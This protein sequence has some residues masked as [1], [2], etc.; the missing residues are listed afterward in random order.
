MR[1]RARAIVIPI[2]R[3]TG[4]MCYQL[5]CVPTIQHCSDPIQPIPS[6]LIPCLT[7]GKHSICFCW[8]SELMHLLPTL[9]NIYPS[10]PFWTVHPHLQGCRLLLLVILVT[11]YFFH[12]IPDP[13]DSMPSV[14]PNGYHPW[15]SWNGIILLL[16]FSPSYQTWIFTLDLYNA[17]FLLE[18]AD[19]C[20]PIYFW[21]S[22]M[23]FLFNFWKFFIPYFLLLLLSFFHNT[24][25]TLSGSLCGCFY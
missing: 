18:L 9:F 6:F 5:L 14:F 4:F 23:I 10:P 25:W 24:K 22:F 15:N 1:Q 7:Y 21:Y 2:Y 8:M 12:S 16:S 13:L 20:K 19:L 11:Q 3:E 17:N